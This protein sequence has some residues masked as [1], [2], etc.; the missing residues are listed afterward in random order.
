MMALA[1]QQATDMPT[2]IAVEALWLVGAVSLPILIVAA[3]VGLI[4]AALQA[5]TQIQDPTVAHLPRLI[6]VVVALAALGP[7][8]AQEV[9]RFAER[10]II[11]AAS[12]R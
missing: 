3:L 1:M 6:V 10:C 5:A 11:Q 9:A 7:W 12:V 8:M 2:G 4:V